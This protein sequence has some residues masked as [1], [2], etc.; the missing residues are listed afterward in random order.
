LTLFKPDGDVKA[1][2]Q[3]ITRYVMS[4]GYLSTCAQP[5]AMRY[6]LEGQPVEPV[7]EEHRIDAQAHLEVLRQRIQRRAEARR[8]IPDGSIQA[9]A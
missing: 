8:T 9:P 7:S 2:R 1:L 3:A 5:G 6:N 4:K